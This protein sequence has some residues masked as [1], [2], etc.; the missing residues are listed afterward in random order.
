MPS[1]L[2]IVS[3]GSGGSRFEDWTPSM[4]TIPGSGGSG[5]I[6]ATDPTLASS[7]Q[8][9]SVHAGWRRGF[10]PAHARTVAVYISGEGEIETTDGDVRRVSPGTVLLTEDTTGRGHAARVTG[11]DPVVVIHIGLAE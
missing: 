2:R 7:W 1:F 10:A 4:G 8:I 3:D 11:P 5:P 6:L 9:R